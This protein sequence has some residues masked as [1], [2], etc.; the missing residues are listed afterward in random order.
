MVLIISFKYKQDY[1]TSHRF[2][3][4]IPI[5]TIFYYSWQFFGFFL[6]DILKNI[7]LNMG[8]ILKLYTFVLLNPINIVFQSLNGIGQLIGHQA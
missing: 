8:D 1:I 5:T 6:A 3:H 4:R 7:L 2:A